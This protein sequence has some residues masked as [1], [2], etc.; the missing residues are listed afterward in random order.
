M[1][2]SI[3]DYYSPLTTKDSKELSNTYKV[4]F[5]DSFYRICNSIQQKHKYVLEDLVFGTLI[6]LIATYTNQD[7]VLIGKVNKNDIFEYYPFETSAELT[8]L[9]ILNI[10]KT[11]KQKKEFL[12]DDSGIN[13]DILVTDSDI[14]VKGKIIFVC[15]NNEIVI[16]DSLLNSNYKTTK[17]INHFKCLLTSYTRK[18][19]AQ[20]DT[21]DMLTESE[22][23]II[24]GFS[25]GESV[26][27]NN[28]FIE[29]FEIQVKKNP[30]S[31]AVQI[32]EEM[33]SY[34]FINQKANQFGRLFESMGIKKN[35]LVTI[36]LERNEWFLVCILALWKIGAI[37]IPIDPKIPQKRVEM[38]LDE[39]KSRY[40]ITNKSD[41]SNLSNRKY[42][43]ISEIINEHVRFDKNNI[44]KLINNHD[45]AYVIFTSGSTG[46]PKGAM[47]EHIG[48]INHIWAKINDFKLSQTSI[49]AQNASQSFDISVWQMFAP[50]AIGGRTVIY[51]DNVIRNVRKFM[52]SISDDTIT[53]LEVVPTYLISILKFLKKNIVDLSKLEFLLVTG[54]VL[55]KDIA[56][57][58]FDLNND[59]VLSNVY[60]PTEASDD[61]THFIVEEKIESSTNS[62]PIGKPIQNMNVYV[63]D[64]FN[65]FCPIG[66]KGEIFVSGIG[67][68]PGYLNNQSKTNDVFFFNN[69]LSESRI[70]RTGDLGYWDQSGNLNF[71][72][73]KDFQVKVRGH[74]IEIEEVERNIIKIHGIDDVVVHAVKDKDDNTVLTAYYITSLET[75]SGEMIKEMLYKFLPKYMVPMF[76]VKMDYFPLNSNGKVDRKKLPYPY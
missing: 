12:E 65:K 32:G 43:I 10:V 15:S 60:G 35:E 56:Q 6:M 70:Y 5:D 31:I 16:K 44:N 13:V 55:K 53:V 63:L 67:V 28:N 36:K 29:L 48:M 26:L 2:F 64:Q 23:E 34:Q 75:L 66:I 33:F 14:E 7:K 8:F 50:L 52:K 24:E 59:V 9:D 46:K 72:G 27:I 47:V 62:I 71:I 37:Y 11:K 39:S 41:L 40:I 18:P 21:I 22:K 38:I 3:E 42:F 76:W 25:C 51:G 4:D 20:V 30:E 68:G 19:T 61:I 17:L 45:L 49:V 1:E 69:S 57:Q 74:R 58:W 73:R 54:E